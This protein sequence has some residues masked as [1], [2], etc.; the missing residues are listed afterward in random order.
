MDAAEDAPVHI[1]DSTQVDNEENL[2]DIIGEPSP[3][4]IWQTLFYKYDEKD[5]PLKLTINGKA[6]T[7]FN[8]KPLRTG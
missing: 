8:G 1:N 4:L 5:T 2:G 3:E 7:E 6:I